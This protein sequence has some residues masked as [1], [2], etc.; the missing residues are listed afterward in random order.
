[1]LRKFNIKAIFRDARHFQI[2]YLGFFLIIGIATLGWDLEGWNFIAI[3][4]AALIT[5]AICIQLTTKN[6]HSL[7]SGMI[8][9]LGLCLLLKANS[10]WVLALAAT[11]A[12]SAKFLIRY[13]N[14]HVFNPA[15][16]GIIIAIL[17]TG[18]AWISPGQWGSA[19]ILFFL[20]GALGLIVLLKVGRLDISLTFL[21][22][23]FLF[24]YLRTVVYLGWEWDVL[25]HKFTNGSFLLFTF[26]MIT[27]PVTTPNSPKARIIWAI[28]LAALSFSLTSW[29]YIHTAPIWALFFISPITVI[30]DRKLKGKRF[31]WFERKSEFV[32]PLKSIHS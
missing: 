14:K 7:K 8:T 23:F 21:L 12:I 4:S 22:T 19:S 3:I 27:D 32:Q 16:F 28:M 26:F 29:F 6:W 24:E 25:L 18:D 31:Q 2:L 1:M 5:Q 17:L 15:N 10:P 20:I 30:L 11:A 9:A 13:K